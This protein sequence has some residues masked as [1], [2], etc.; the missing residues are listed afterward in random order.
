MLDLL[1]NVEK[2]VEIVYTYGQNAINH[3]QGFFAFVGE[4]LS[5]V[6]SAVDNCIPAFLVP[7]VLAAVGVY[8]SAHVVRW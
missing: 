8:I 1:E 7:V 2:S 5:T 4:G 6:Y 3:A